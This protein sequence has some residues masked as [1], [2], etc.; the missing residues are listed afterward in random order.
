MLIGLRY[1][2]N[3]ATKLQ[4]L[5][6]RFQQLRYRHTT[7][8]FR[9]A[10]GVTH[11]ISIPLADPVSRAQLDRSRNLLM[12]D[13]V[14]DTIPTE[15][16]VRPA[17]QS[18]GIANISLEPVNPL[19]AARDLLQNLDLETI[20]QQS[21]EACRSTANTDPSEKADG[22]IL[23]SV[24]GLKGP[25]KNLSTTRALS[26]LVTDPENVLP[27]FLFRI[28][29]HLHR[30][31]LLRRRQWL[32]ENSPLHVKFLDTCMLHTSGH[33][34]DL[35]E[36]MPK[37]LTR[38]LTVDSTRMYEKYR[39]FRWAENILLSRISISEMR[40]QNF[41]LGGLIV[42]QG[43]REIASVALP[44]ASH[45]DPAADQDGVEFHPA[46]PVRGFRPGAIYN[47]DERG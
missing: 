6:L 10:P 41:Q 15:A 35:P 44:G 31:E 29:K 2:S 23:A 18:I 47:V 5:C 22:P 20:L 27:E 24:V 25:E 45:M 19:K 14:T 3:K 16:F 43:Y 9:Y 36:H 34:N 26:T 46:F 7:K 42:D 39:Y 8:N 37:L 4:Q 17:S 1:R 13:P 30:A 40:L 32:R 33:I 21:R 11:F 28:R 12:R 38:T